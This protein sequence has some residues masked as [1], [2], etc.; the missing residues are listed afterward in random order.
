M[1]TVAITLRATIRA[2]LEHVFDFVVAEDVLPKVL[3]G[4]GPLPAVT[5][6]SD[7]HG[8]WDQPGSYRIKSAIS[9][10]LCATSPQ[11]GK[12][13]G[14]FA[15]PLKAHLFAGGTRIRPARC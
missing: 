12:D 11:R 6:T 15:Q 3:L 5:S 10:L 13:N 8:R 7:L 2:S 14:G 9:R 1:P 4:Y